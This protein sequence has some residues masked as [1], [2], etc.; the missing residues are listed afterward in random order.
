MDGVMQYTIS[1]PTGRKFTIHAQYGCWWVRD[2]AHYY[3]VRGSSAVYCA[4]AI[5]RGST[6]LG[7]W[8]ATCKKTIFETQPKKSYNA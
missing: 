5:G 7:D 6:C 2:T 4:L 3:Q 1:I 8:L